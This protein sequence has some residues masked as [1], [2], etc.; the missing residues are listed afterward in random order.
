MVHPA[1]LP[2]QGDNGLTFQPNFA[3]CSLAT[4]LKA[5]RPAFEVIIMDTIYRMPSTRHFPCVHA[6]SFTDEETKA[7]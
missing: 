1:E 6:P 3:P 5:N 4:K 7:R 2:S